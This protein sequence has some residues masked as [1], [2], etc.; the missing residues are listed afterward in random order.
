M[1]D[2]LIENNVK[3]LAMSW[4]GDYNI[5]V[6]KIYKMLDLPIVKKH[7]TFRYLFDRNAE[8]KRFTNEKSNKM[9][10]TKKKTT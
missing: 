3:E 2:A 8:F 4:V 5:T 6:N 9:Q 1:T 10:K 7:A